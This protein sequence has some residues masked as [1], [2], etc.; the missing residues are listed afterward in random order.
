MNICQKYL[1]RGGVRSPGIA[2]RQLQPRLPVPQ[3]LFFIG[4]PR[5]GFCGRQ[6]EPIRPVGQRPF[7]LPLSTLLFPDLLVIH[8]ISVN[9]RNVVFKV[10]NN[11]LCSC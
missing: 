4:R 7:F 8:I 3:A 1:T 10:L 6:L 2:A 11:S 9:I 5:A